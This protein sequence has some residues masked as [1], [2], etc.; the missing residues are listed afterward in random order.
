MISIAKSQSKNYHNLEFDA[1]NVFHK[2][3]PPGS[4]DCVVSIATF[5]HYLLEDVLR[6]SMEWLKKDG[7]L[8]VFDVY[9]PKTFFDYVYS[10]FAVI[11]DVFLNFIK[12]GRVRESK[13]IRRVWNNHSKNDRVITFNEVCKAAFR[14]SATVKIHRHLFWRYSMICKKYN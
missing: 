8:V 11:P 2:N 12:N 5:H 6:R 14:A 7:I 1:I 9:K 13:Q 4:F 3:I 10:L